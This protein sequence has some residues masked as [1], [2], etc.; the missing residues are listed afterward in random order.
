MRDLNRYVI[1]KHADHWK[2]IGLELELELDTLNIISKDNKNDCVACFQITLDK[3]LKFNTNAT[4]RILEV[5]I[6]NVRRVHLG[7]EPVTDIYVNAV[8]ILLLVITLYLSLFIDDDILK[9]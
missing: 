6:T 2:D 3:W 4:W 1:N 8:S 7:L 5:A 9:V